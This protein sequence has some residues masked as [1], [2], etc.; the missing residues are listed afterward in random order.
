MYDTLYIICILYYTLLRCIVLDCIMLCYV[1]L[2]L[3][4]LLF[5]ARSASVAADLADT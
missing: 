2:G 3:I 1:I 5:L 4:L